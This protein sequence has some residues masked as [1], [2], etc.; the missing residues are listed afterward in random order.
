MHET[1]SHPDLTG[2]L[3]DRETRRTREQ[4]DLDELDEQR[5]AGK[6]PGDLANNAHADASAERKRC[7]ATAALLLGLQGLVIAFE[8]AVLALE[9]LDP[10]RVSHDTR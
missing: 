3:L 9:F 4:E 8:Q 5:P 1:E 10:R 7:E 6:R 2:S